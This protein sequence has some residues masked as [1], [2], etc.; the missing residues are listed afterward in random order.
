MFQKS[1]LG[2]KIQKFRRIGNIS[3]G[4][5]VENF[6]GKKSQIFEF[7]RLK[8]AKLSYFVCNIFWQNTYFW[9]VNSNF[10][11]ISRSKIQK[12]L[13]IFGAKIQK[14]RILWYLDKTQFLA[15]KNS[16]FSRLKWAILPQLV[17]NIFYQN[18]NFFNISKSIDFWRQNS[19]KLNL[20]FLVKIQFLVQK[21]DF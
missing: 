16:Q 2:P 3:F 10:F 17:W 5:K 1:I 18:S 13:L 12:N 21:I 11:S 4:T 14:R 6:S 15:P 7:S 9:R 19:K 20:R 8:W